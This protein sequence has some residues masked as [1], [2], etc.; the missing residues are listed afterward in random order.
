MKDAGVEVFE[1]LGGAPN[2]NSAGQ[3]LDVGEPEIVVV[4]VVAVAFADN[5]T[6]DGRVSSAQFRQQQ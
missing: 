6:S 5:C 1:R 2:W 3:N 4:I